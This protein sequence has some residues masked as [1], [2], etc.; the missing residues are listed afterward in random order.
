MAKR[1]AKKDG[2]PKRARSKK[3][4]HPLAKYG[5]PVTKSDHVAVE[6][7]CYFDADA[8]QH[9]VEFFPSFLHHWKGQFAGQPFELLE[10]QRDCIAKAF[11]WK[12]P[13]G[14]RRFRTMYI[15]VPKKNGKA[16][17]VDTPIPTTSGW[18]SMGDIVE[19]D[20]LFDENGKQTRVLFA[21]DF[22]FG[23]KCYR[24]SFSD[25]TSI[26]A[27]EEH[28]WKTEVLTLEYKSKISTTSE[29]RDSLFTRSDGARNHRI[30]VCKPLETNELGI[31]I[32]KFVCG[33]GPDK[34]FVEITSI[35][36][37][38]SVPV[39]CI[40]VDSK[41]NLFLA[42]DGM[43]P[44]HNTPLAAAIGHLLLCA[45]GEQGATVIVAANT[46]P[47]A[48]LMYDEAT[49]MVRGTDLEQ[50]LTITPSTKHISV[51]QTSSK[52][53]VI[54]SEAYSA[55]G[56]NF[57]ALL[58][59][60]FHALKDRRFWDALRY[61]G[62]ARRQ[63]MIVIITTAGYDRESVCWNMHE[64]ALGILDGTFVDEAMLPV[65]YGAT[66]DDD[67]MAPETWRKANP[68]MGVTISEDDFARECQEAAENP[69]LENAFKR[70]RLNIWTQQATR[71][72]PMEQ[73][74]RCGVATS[75][76]EYHGLACTGGLDL[77]SRQDIT[78]LSL[79]FPDSHSVIQRAWVPR[80]AAED[81][82]KRGILPSYFDL[83]N[84]GF[85][86]LTPGNVIDYGFIVREIVEMAAMFRIIGIA[87]DPWNATQTAIQLQDE[88][89]IQAVEFRQNYSSMTGPCNELLRL[90]ISCQLNHRFNPLLEWAASN[91]AVRSG[92]TGGIMF[93]KESSGEK[94]D[95]IVS[96]AMAIGL[97]IV[98]HKQDDFVGIDFF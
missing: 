38:A 15:E 2:T 6:H 98:Q 3:T 66:E 91:A 43:I 73:W 96:L 51:E 10:W 36:E 79:Y 48:G 56:L 70:Y 32:Q 90:V 20:V 59:D 7:G 58:Y 88:H 81:R 34:G 85:L 21:T 65:W 40:K 61:G 16:L 94:I 28:L 76:S 69:L 50:Y 60:E 1:A 18:K 8:A 29:L 55:E 14:T 45:D 62:A 77:S 71:F 57:S 13:D 25:G 74:R 19:G 22:M 54:A 44:T 12:R 24:V 80:I 23:H 4:A 46:V 41:S 49:H 39:K 42:G 82:E 92:P 72:I 63:P 97:S 37:V 67:W 47:Q 33:A 86:T 78:S 53:R 89:G 68:S 95:P 84:N 9:A 87:Y 5:K 52:M 31:D 27:D 75:E 30:P 26:V 11:G 17:A 83:A 35:E 64:R 93:D